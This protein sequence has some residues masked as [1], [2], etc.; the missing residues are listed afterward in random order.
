VD[1][2]LGIP[3]AGSTP[4]F[5]SSVFPDVA[6]I[7]DHRS[8]PTTMIEEEVAKYEVDVLIGISFGAHISAISAAHR[9]DLSGLVLI[10]PAWTG[11]PSTGH[12]DLATTLA[13][14]GVDATLANVPDEPSW[15]KQ[16]LHDAWASFD[17]SQL[18]QHLG[19]TANSR[20]PSPTELTMIECPTVIVSLCDDPVHPAMIA[21]EW[22]AMVRHSRLIEIPVSSPQNCRRNLGTAALANL[23]DFRTSFE[24][25]R[26]FDTRGI[27]NGGQL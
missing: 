21:A 12:K 22:H 27:N 6:D 8:T 24:R 11:T 14:T 13:R 25:I 4:E 3:G 5:F 2:V 16:E 17:E 15:V 1:R 7:I 23:A 10:A 9:S 26:K 18:A 19:V 20:G